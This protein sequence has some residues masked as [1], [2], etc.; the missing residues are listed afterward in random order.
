MKITPDKPKPGDLITIE[1]DWKN[2]PLFGDEM[3]ELV[4]MEYADK[5]AFARDIALDYQ[6][7]VFKGSI[8][9]SKLAQAACF[10]FKAGPRWDNQGGNGYFL[11]IYDKSGKILPESKVAKAQ[12]LIGNAGSFDIKANPVQANQWLDEAFAAQASLRAP[13]LITYLR[14]LINIK[15]GAAGKPEALTLL[16]ELEKSG[17]ATEKDWIAAVRLYEFL[18]EMEKAQAL[19]EQIR[20]T[21]PKGVYLQQERR[22]AV[23]AE[24]DTLRRKQ[25][26]LAYKKDFPP[27]TESERKDLSRMYAGLA[28]LY[29]ENNNW[30]GFPSFAGSMDAATRAALY[31]DVAWDQANAGTNLPR[32]LNLSEKAMRWA[33]NQIAAPETERPPQMNA[34]RALEQRRQ[35]YASYADT[36]A[37]VLGKLERWAEAAGIQQEAVEIFEGNNTEMN[38]RFIQYLEKSQAPELRYQLEG[39]V[40]KGQA[41]TA[42]KEAFRKQLGMAD[43]SEAGVVAYMNRVELAAKE[44]LRKSLSEKMTQVAAADFNLKT[45]EGKSV[46]LASLR[47]K[48]V[49]VDFWAT[50]CGPCKASFPAMQK[51]QNEYAKDS[52]V[53]FLFI[54]TWERVSM[55]G[56]AK[57]AGDFILEK[58]YPFQVL[59]DLEDA[60]VAAFGVSGIPTKFVLDAQGNIRFKSI[61]WGGDAEALVTELGLMIE[62]AKLPLK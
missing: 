44:R 40:L 55:E 27:K 5:T 50:W 36:Y 56:K 43:K 61:G 30:S 29:A 52:S 57:L 32:A 23:S 51:S 25:L 14:N 17:Q 45:L 7:Q 58:G 10:A 59:L 4:F 6:N 2:S 13:N 60:T 22:Q 33:R 16:A 1:Y 38:D 48:V 62:L 8:V 34:E 3:L 19:K 31:N 20:R 11:D 39:F 18:Q 54:N 53:V 12:L 21:F 35:L 24:P 47:G 15:R 37:F 42:M 26:L 41:N 46:S 9:L 49:V 28:T